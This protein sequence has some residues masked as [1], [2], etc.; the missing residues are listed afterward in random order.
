MPDKACGWPLLNPEN[1]LRSQ[2]MNMKYALPIFLATFGC[3]LCARAL[4]V[5][6]VTARQRWPWNNLVDIDFTVLANGTEGMTEFGVAVTASYANGTKTVTPSTFTSE[7]LATA[8]TNR[9]TWNL[10]ADCPCLRAADLAITVSVST[11]TAETPAYLVVDLSGGASATSYPVHYTSRAPDPSNTTCRT[12]ELWLRRVLAGSFTMGTSSSELGRGPVGG[13]DSDANQKDVTLTRAYYVGVFQV[14]QR[15]WYNVMGNWPSYLTNA[16][17]RDLRPVEQV[18]YDLIRG[19]AAQGGGGWPTNSGIYADSFVG[20]LRLKTGLSS[21]DLPTE[22]QWEFACRA[23]TTTA[24]YSGMNLTNVTSDAN[25]AVLARY[26]YNS[27][28][29]GVNLP[30]RACGFEG[31]TSAVGSYR[32]NAWGLYDMLGNTYEWCLDWYTAGVIPGG[33]DPQGFASGT[34]RVRRG[35]M[36]TSPASQCRVGMRWKKG[37]SDTGSTYGC[38]FR[39]AKQP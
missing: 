7:F 21:L 29:D 9:V 14:T 2:T 11:N 23:G 16:V 19:A 6:N 18:T 22:A 17:C 35:G 33:T 39:I 38:G 3:L 5:T 12:S 36:F 32:P 28:Y 8:G 15:Q 24:L 10:G 25:V 26:Q 30:A 37:P 27:G 13:L 31:G 34:E 20:R 1:R 4:D